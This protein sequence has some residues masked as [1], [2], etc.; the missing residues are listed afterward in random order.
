[1]GAGSVEEV[2]RRVHDEVCSCADPANWSA[3]DLETG[4]PERFY[5]EACWFRPNIDRAVRAGYDLARAAAARAF[6]SG[7]HEALDNVILG[8]DPKEMAKLFQEPPD[9]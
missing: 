2:V 9:L 8:A 1:M 3:H 4:Q 5:R 7:W 6:R